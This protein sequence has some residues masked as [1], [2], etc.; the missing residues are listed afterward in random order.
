[1]T[2]HKLLDQEAQTPAI[3]WEAENVYLVFCNFS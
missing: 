1:M 3:R 2:F